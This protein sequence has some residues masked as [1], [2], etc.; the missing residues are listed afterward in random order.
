[1]P[2]PTLYPLGSLHALAM[3]ES[4]LKVA[5]VLGGMVLF[6]ILAVLRTVRKVSETQE[7]E[8]TKREVAAYVAEGS[9]TPDDATRILAAG[10][11]ETVAAE[12]A[13]GVTWGTVSAAKAQKMVQALQQP[14]G[15]GP[16]AGPAAPP[17]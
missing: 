1:M 14:L 2:A 9:M 4:E 11:S 15:S 5:V 13:R 6:A 17:R 3:N 8:R 7:R 10:M 16:N 12:L